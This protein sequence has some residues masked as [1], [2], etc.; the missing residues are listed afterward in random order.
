MLTIRNKMLMIALW[1]VCSMALVLYF[2][3]GKTKSFDEFG[4][5]ASASS[6]SSFD[7]SVADHLKNSTDSLANKTVHFTQE[8]C[9]C[10]LIAEPHINS[11]K[12]LT[13]D[14][15]GSN[16]HIVINS[17]E[18]TYGFVPAT[19]AVAVFDQHENLIYLGPYST[20]LFCAPSEGIVERFIQNRNEAKQAAATVLMEAEGCYCSV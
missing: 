11:V 9:F 6:D 13:N 19:P 14:L 4:I 7:K 8:D 12:T 10:N 5:L 20:G 1:A 15:S 18:N 17:E 2:S 3:V 16:E